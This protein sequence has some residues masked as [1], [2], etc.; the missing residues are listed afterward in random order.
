MHT[1]AYLYLLKESYGGHIDNILTGSIDFCASMP[2]LWLL[3]QTSLLCTPFLGSA[4]L[5]YELKI[6]RLT[7]LS[8]CAG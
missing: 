3:E 4:R 8:I 1:D 6:V 7:D 2:Y 5:F